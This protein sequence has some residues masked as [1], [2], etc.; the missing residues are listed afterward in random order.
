ML[1][2]GDSKV[3]TLD[4]LPPHSIEAEQGVLG[5]VLSSPIECIPECVARLTPGLSV[6]YDMRHQNLYAALLKMH[7]MCEPIDTITVQ[8]RLKDD[9]ALDSI[10]GLAYMSG[11]VDL[12][13]SAAHLEYYLIIVMEKY[14]LRCA[15]AAGT[16][17]VRQSMENGDIDVIVSEI[18]G[19]LKGIAD[20]RQ[21]IETRANIA[22][23]VQ[24]SIDE[25]ERVFTSGDGVVGIK[26]GFPDLDIITAG[27]QPAVYIIAARP[28]A[29]KTTLAMNI[30]EHVAIAL[31]FP[32]GVFSLEMTARALIH[33]MMGARARVNTRKRPSEADFKALTAAAGAI[34]GAPLVIE[35]APT[36]AAVMRARARRM[37]QQNGCKLLI[38]DYLQRC[39]SG[40][41][42]GNREQEVAEVSRAIADTA[43]ELAVPFIALCQLNRDCER[44][45]R[46]PRM[47][48]LRES[49][50]VEAD[51]DFIGILYRPKAKKGE[52]E[53][54]DSDICDVAMTVE[55]QRNGS[56]GLI[57]FVFKK[58]I[59]RFES[60]ARVHQDDV[61]GRREPHND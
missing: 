39:G 26:T 59:T 18:E 29:G 35:D 31:R 48:D 23:C 6:F 17:L 32:V 42:H 16:E 9:G 57:R 19:R 43:K 11:L 5:C 54:D 25:I 21:G 40:N 55:K 36:T 24:S 51:A 8:R 33:R 58:T 7:Q 3:P 61:P 46:K 10:G 13:P 34:R 1:S 30:A 52:E 4:R 12:I 50:A 44:E 27:L 56:T 28:G 47:S 60:A 20:A 53:D 41:R 14:A 2:K 37:V 45:G 22:E 49:G 15:V 38:L